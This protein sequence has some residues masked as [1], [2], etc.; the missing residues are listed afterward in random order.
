MATTTL[1]PLQ[2]FFD[3]TTKDFLNGGKVYSYAAQS[4]TPQ[5]I[6]NTFDTS[7]PLSNPATLGTDGKID[8]GMWGSGSYKLIVK[9][10]DGSQTVWTVD[11]VSSGT[12]VLASQIIGNIS[13]SA[14]TITTT[15]GDITL[16]SQGNVKFQVL[17]TNTYQMLGTSTSQAKLS[18][19]E[20]TSNGSNSFT[21]VPPAAITSDRTMTLPDASVDWA[22]INYT[23]NN[24][25]VATVSADA[26]S[27]G[28]Q[29]LSQSTLTQLALGT[30]N[31]NTG[32]AFSS[33][34]FTAP[35][36]G[37]YM[38]NAGF[39][40]QSSAALFQFS[41]YIYK[42]GSAYRTAGQL[43]Q[44][45]GFISINLSCCISLAA[46]DTITLYGFQNSVSVLPA[47]ATISI[48]RIS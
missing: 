24:A 40:I 46:S 5:S 44:S 37:V 2:Q 4:S 20:Q 34:T 21:F 16:G 6:Y 31:N 11:N 45:G 42:N 35:Y 14:N 47:S 48:A 41:A 33:N 30:V 28:T 22:N 29:N 8:G 36:A 32:S 19:F 17:G 9:S 26:Q 25:L 10:S 39:T 3:P 12:A 27:T 15:T 38:I 23:A 43:G 7:T 13:I 1:L 18:L